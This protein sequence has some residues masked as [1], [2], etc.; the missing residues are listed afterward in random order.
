MNKTD[1]NIYKE[2]TSIS[3]HITLDFKGVSV[4]LRVDPVLPVSY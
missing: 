4:I 3:C 1:V 2:V